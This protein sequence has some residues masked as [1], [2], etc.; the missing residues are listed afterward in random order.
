MNASAFLRDF[1]AK[2]DWNAQELA[3]ATYRRSRLFRALYPRRFRLYHVGIAKAGTHSIAAIFAKHHLSAHEPEAYRTIDLVVRQYEGQPSAAVD[4]ELLLRDER[5]YLEVEASHIISELVPNLV[6]LFPDAK[7]LLTLRDPVS[8]L[9]SVIQQ[10]ERTKNLRNVKDWERLRVCRW[11]NLAALPEEA[12]FRAAGV[13]SIAG[14]LARFR[15]HHECVLKAVP[16][17]RLL[18]LPM[19]EIGARLGEIA[20]FAG[21]PRSSVRPEAAHSYKRITNVSLLD[22]VPAEYID[23]LVQRECGDLVRRFFPTAKTMAERRAALTKT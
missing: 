8:W 5:L 11:G 15:N 22:C 19:Q 17:D 10:V 12:A 16:S 6:R 23:G 21:V 18:I 3:L 14:S 2:I 7:F 20:D 13:V 4:A 9:E 1:K